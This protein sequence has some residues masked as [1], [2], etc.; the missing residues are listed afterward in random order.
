[1]LILDVCDRSPV[2]FNIGLSCGAADVTGTLQGVL[3]KRK[4][5]NS[6][7]KPGIQIDNGPQF[8]S[9]KLRKTARGSAFIING[10]PLSP[11]KAYMEASMP[12]IEDECLSVMN[13]KPMLRLL[14]D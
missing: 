11:K 8:I 13:A 14:A 3:F 7:D 10:Y 12:I 4:L 2:D 5:F 9:G 6:T 1:M